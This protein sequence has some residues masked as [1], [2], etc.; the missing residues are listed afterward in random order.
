MENFLWIVVF[1]NVS[2]NSPTIALKITYS[3][4]SIGR[5]G[6][7]AA[8]HFPLLLKWFAFKGFCDRQES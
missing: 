4:I 6:A 3:M 5:E 8:K 1:C 7:A 2:R